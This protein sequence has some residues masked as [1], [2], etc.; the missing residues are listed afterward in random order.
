MTWWMEHLILN[1]FVFLLSWGYAEGKVKDGIILY[2][3][4]VMA[5][6]GFMGIFCL[7]IFNGGHIG[8]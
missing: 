5:F 1:V 4:F 7:I 6:Y 3:L 8:I 2:L